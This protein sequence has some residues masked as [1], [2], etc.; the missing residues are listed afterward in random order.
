MMQSVALTDSCQHDED[1]VIVE[2]HES[3]SDIEAEQA[4]RNSNPNHNCIPTYVYDDADDDDDDLAS[5]DYCEDAYSVPST[6]VLQSD[7]HALETVTFSHEFLDYPLSYNL[8]PP[9]VASTCAPKILSP[10]ILS[11]LF[12]F[13]GAANTNNSDNIDEAEAETDSVTVDDG[14]ASIAASEISAS[15]RDEGERVD[16][17][18]DSDNEGV[19]SDAVPN[20]LS[21]GSSVAGGSGA[22]SD[23]GTSASS[24]SSSASSSVVS[25]YQTQKAHSVG[26]SDDSSVHSTSSKKS[27]RVSNKKMRKQLKLVQKERVAAAAAALSPVVNRHHGKKATMG[28]KSK[29]AGVM[30]STNKKQVAC[31]TQG[32]SEY[33]EEVIRN[34]KSF[35]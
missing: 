35:R 10:G 21:P 23:R 34:N 3:S 27:C 12:P 14:S 11:S 15:T 33:R 29:K 32:L 22:G 31:A 19:D 9:D 13:G 1:F 16:H 26:I 4:E 2:A 25:T 24:S 28:K 6:S 18:K 8:N 30:R 5:Y 7:S 17:V 20:T